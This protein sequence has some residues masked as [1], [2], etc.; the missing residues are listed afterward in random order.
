MIKHLPRSSMEFLLHIFNLSWTLHSFPSIWK[1][2][3][4]IPIPKWESLSTLLL[5]SGLSLSPPAYQSCLNASFYRVYSSFWNLIPFSLL[6]RPVSALDGLLWI[7]FCIFLSAFTMGLTNPGRALGRFFL[8]SISLKLLTLS[9]ILP[10]SK[11]LF[12]LASLLALLV[13]LNLSFLIGALA[14]SIKITKVV[15]FKCVEVF[16]KD[17]FLA[18]YFSLS[19][20]NDLPAP[21][22]SSVSCSL[23]ADDQAIWSSGPSVPTAVEATQGV[24]FRLERWSEY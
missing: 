3:F 23:Y 9:G 4:I 8:L 16:C 10:F 14:W 24:L 21:L 17:P 1:T 6:A 22:P 13:G 2:S 18:G 19:S 20:S 11:N 7:K 12:P 5:P 15:S